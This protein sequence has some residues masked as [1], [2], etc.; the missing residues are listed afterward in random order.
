MPSMYDIQMQGENVWKIA[1]FIYKHMPRAHQ[2]IHTYMYIV[3]RGQFCKGELGRNLEPTQTE[4]AYI[5][6]YTSTYSKAW[7]F[8]VGSKTH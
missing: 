3:A 8:S 6:T 1:V 5:S 2:A 7:F 4:F